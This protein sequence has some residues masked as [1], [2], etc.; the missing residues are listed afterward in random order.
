MKRLAAVALAATLAV[1][2]AHAVTPNVLGVTAYV[3][4]TDTSRQ[5]AMQ[6]TVEWLTAMFAQK[7]VRFTVMPGQSI[8]TYAAN[9]ALRR[10]KYYSPPLGDSLTFTGV[11]HIGPKMGFGGSSHTVANC[12]VVNS[13]PYDI[14]R[15]TTANGFAP[16]A[17]GDSISLSSGTGTIPTPGPRVVYV[18]SL[19]QRAYLTDVGSSTTNTGVTIRWAHMYRP[20][21]LS[22]RPYMPSAPQWFVGAQLGGDGLSLT[23]GLQSYAYTHINAGANY[24]ATD[25]SSA[26][27]FRVG[28]SNKPWLFSK[29]YKGVRAT[30][31]DTVTRGYRPIVGWYAANG[32]TSEAG[33]NANTDYSVTLDYDRPWRTRGAWED[34]PDTLSGWVVTNQYVTAS[35][36]TRSIRWSTT[37]GDSAAWMGFC[38]VA[39]IS[40]SGQMDVAT[41]MA[42]GNVLD[43]A[44]AGAFFGYPYAKRADGAM[45]IDDGWK[46]GNPH[47][48][49][50]IQISS[51]AVSPLG[52][53][54]GAYGAMD[55]ALDSTA[56]IA[57]IDSIAT[58]MKPFVLGVEGD[59]LGTVLTNQT[60][61]VASRTAGNGMLYDGRWWSR[62][63][64]YI[65]YT[66][67][68]HAGGLS[69]DISNQQNTG[70]TPYLRP[71]DIWGKTRARWAWGSEDS[72][73]TGHYA[74]GVAAD[75]VTP[76]FTPL[77][78]D[79]VLEGSLLRGAGSDTG[80]VYW[81]AKRSFAILDSTFG[82]DKV[83]HF[84][85]PPYDDYSP[86]SLVVSGGGGTSGA[87][88]AQDSV[89]AAWQLA[90]GRGIRFNANS[91]ASGGVAAGNP[92]AYGYYSHR[93]EIPGANS[94]PA[95][96]PSFA[97]PAPGYLLGCGGYMSTASRRPYFETITMAKAQYTLASLALGKPGWGTDNVSNAGANSF[98]QWNIL[99]LHV[100]DLSI[101]SVLPI[102]YR[103]LAGPN[104]DAYT[105]ANGY[106]RDYNGIVTR[107]G[108]YAMKYMSNMVDAINAGGSEMFRIT[109]PELIRP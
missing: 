84:G 8:T 64:P 62:A 12:S 19:N 85:M 74:T 96:L 14:M 36:A 9:D 75:G 107:P 49:T 102:R 60:N 69:T 98:G 48:S 76:T 99:A 79:Y 105:R 70:G 61:T 28:M 21:L 2:T 72:T 44:S 92:G 77:T 91:P 73:L 11:V 52:Y 89:F 50:G 3:D 109:Y 7:G 39:G 53:Y 104:Y 95:W 101:G 68:C 58:L 90:G 17:P 59:S 24:A 108:W 22:T 78:Q 10:A 80:S 87:V 30:A 47:D 32:F 86:Q 83:D 65:H 13:T 88:L 56:T 33:D 29:A 66:L 67:H 106:M 27:S 57:S 45:H 25:D 94:S 93:R 40:M 20:D 6:Q 41:V 63:N 42:V 23:G 54:G 26:R 103:E 34:N 35:G 1:S 82:A 81:L 38:G 18:D 46:R 5:S 4:P 55:T 31:A 15:T 71:L 37:P 51:G 100:S 97:K 16:I 43:S